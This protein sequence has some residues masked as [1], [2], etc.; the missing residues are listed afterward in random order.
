MAEQ[1]GGYRKPR[2]PA[3]VS[4]PGSMSRRTDDGR[5]QAVRYM[6]GGRYGEGKQLLE[7]QQGAP[8]AGKPRITPGLTSRTINAEQPI[9]PLFAPTRN[10]EEPLTTG[11]DA[12]PGMG[13]GIL[14]QRPS[15][16]TLFDVL[17]QLME[18]DVT[19]DAEL[20]YNYLSSQG[21]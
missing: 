7:Q 12:G 5:K 10:P 1:Q 13:S 11:I 14:Q 3:P 8:M 9:T 17:N 18:N 4:G 2:K 21:Y 15:A 16:P 6:A 19:G 20:L